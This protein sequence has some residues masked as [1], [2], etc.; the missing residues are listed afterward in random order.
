[1]QGGE[2]K[3]G[4]ITGGGLL[5]EV[6]AGLADKTASTERM[7]P[8]GAESLLLGEK[9]R[10]RA[11]EPEDVDLLYA[12]ENDPRVW[13]VGETLAPLSR[14]ALAEFIENQ[15]LDI[16]QTRQLR[17]VICLAS[18]GFP[19]GLV[20]LFD[21]DPVHLRAGVGILIFE[22]CHRGHGFASEALSLL[23]EYAR[24]I[25]NLHQLWA[26]VEASNI[27]SYELFSGKGFVK[28]GVRREWFRRGSEWRDEILLQKIL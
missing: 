12:W 17:L 10:L 21:F 3:G 19:V 2:I 9:V 14:A 28:V 8:A 16:F 7:L 20:D 18:D 27:S 1:M 23:C 15:R 26:G 24:N 22:P 6:A 5:A 4:E 13:S 11:L 25:L